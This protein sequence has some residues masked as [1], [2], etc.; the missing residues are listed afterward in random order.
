MSVCLSH[1]DKGSCHVCG[2]I[3]TFFCFYVWGPAVSLRLLCE[4]STLALPHLSFPC[5]RCSSRLSAVNCTGAVNRCRH[6][7]GQRATFRG[8]RY[9]VISHFKFFFLTPSHSHKTWYYLSA[10]FVT[11]CKTHSLSWLM[12][13]LKQSQRLT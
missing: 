10:V 5:I 13:Y 11:I 9:I 12:A 1:T 4:G 7:L 2:K 8:R 3:F 6:F